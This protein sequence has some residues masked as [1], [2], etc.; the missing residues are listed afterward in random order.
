MRI[1]SLIFVKSLCLGMCDRIDYKRVSNKTHY[2]QGEGE[3]R[4]R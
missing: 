3:E 2:D 4:A 1:N